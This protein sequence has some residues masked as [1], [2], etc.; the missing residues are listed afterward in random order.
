VSLTCVL[1]RDYSEWPRLPRSQ[2]IQ[3]IHRLTRITRNQPASGPRRQPELCRQ[4]PELTFRM[5]VQSAWFRS[6]M[7]RMS[8]QGA[9]ATQRHHAAAQVTG[10]QTTG[11]GGCFRD[12]SQQSDYHL[13]SGPIL[14]GQVN[15][16]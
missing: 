1:N 4:A 5:A 3:W 16:A 11:S 7:Q 8:T 15:T 14:A 10:R 2:R 6:A 12:Q 9:A 13:T